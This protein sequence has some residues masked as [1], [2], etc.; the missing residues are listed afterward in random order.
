[1][2]DLISRQAALS[3]VEKMYK[4]CDGNLSDYHDLLVACFTDLT[5]A[6]QWIPC[7][8]CKPKKDGDYFV[9]YRLE[10]G[11][12]EL[13]VTSDY[14]HVNTD[15]WEVTGSVLAWMPFPEPWKGDTP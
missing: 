5:P 9:T 6:Q 10:F 3:T 13:A 8:T 11:G 14:Y 4:M 7:K 15:E 12:E 2:D 1:M